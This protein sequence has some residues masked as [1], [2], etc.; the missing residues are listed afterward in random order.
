MPRDYSVARIIVELGTR[1]PAQAWSDFLSANASL[2][3]QVVRSF[4]KDSE[5]VAECFLFVCEQLSLNRFRRLRKFRPQG[6][7]R[8]ETWLRAVVRNLCLDWHRKEFGR[9][10]VFRSIQG[11]PALE[12]ELF[13]CVYEQ[14]CSTDYALAWL[15]PR[16]PGITHQVLQKSLER[17]EAALTPRQRWLLTVQ[18]NRRMPATLEGDEETLSAQ[19]LSPHVDPEAQAAISERRGALSQAMKRLSPR[20]RS[21][22]MLRFEEGLTLENL[23]RVFRL[24]DAQTADRRIRHLLAKLRSWMEGASSAEN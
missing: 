7:A 19:L 1:D 8:F 13:R 11:L 20:E 24:P 22:L 10:R 5:H 15:M 21:M 9:L 2:L 18:R 12:Q 17:I 23:A 6:P 3:Y 4:E 14:G 16:F